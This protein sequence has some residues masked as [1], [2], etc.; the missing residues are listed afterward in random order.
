MVLESAQR[1]PFSPESAVQGFWGPW[2]SHALS[3]P[4]GQVISLQFSH[5]QPFSMGYKV[6]LV[7][8]AW[9][10]QHPLW[11]PSQWHQGEASPYAASRLSSGA[12]R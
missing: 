6:M 5:K 12:S 4:S 11:P 9:G 10:G 8:M 1:A 7:T 3:C 2:K